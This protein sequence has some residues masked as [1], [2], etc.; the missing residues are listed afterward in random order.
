MITRGGGADPGGIAWGE[1]MVLEEKVVE[2][3]EV[4]AAV[5]G[6]CS[7]GGGVGVRCQRGVTIP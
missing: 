6:R 7:A 1:V 5:E 4:V 2:E 3:E